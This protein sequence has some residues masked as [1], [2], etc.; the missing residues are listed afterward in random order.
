MKIVLFDC[1]TP[2]DQREHPE[3][4]DLTPLA[5]ALAI[6]VEDIE[7]ERRF[8][9]EMPPKTPKDA[10]EGI[11]PLLTLQVM[12]GPSV[13]LLDGTYQAANLTIMFWASAFLMYTPHIF[14]KANVLENDS[15][16]EWLIPHTNR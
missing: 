7:V 14:L 10:I 3:E 2:A 13:I 6:S 11:K 1:V 15:Q 5:E 16:D 9:G 8:I 12:D 4:I